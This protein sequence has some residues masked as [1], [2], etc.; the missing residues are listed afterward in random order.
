VSSTRLPID[1]IE[2]SGLVRSDFLFRVQG[3][4]IEVPPL[5]ERIEDI[6]LIV[7]SILECCARERGIPAPPVEPGVLDRLARREW[8]GNVRQLENEVRRAFLLH[9]DRLT[10]ASF[11]E[12]GR[13]GTARIF[14]ETVEAP[15]A[16]GATLRAARDAVEKS[17]VLVA[18]R[19]HRGNATRAARALGISRRYL[20]LLLE[21]HGIR[22]A[23]FL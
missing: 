21:K 17:C 9:P 19:S 4:V 13:P 6:P 18:L 3:E 5:R 7:G 23:D 8:P 14:P 1:R 11:E 16:P 2:A 20:G 12:E 10:P 15:P 22:L